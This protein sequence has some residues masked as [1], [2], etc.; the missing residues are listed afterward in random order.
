MPMAYGS[1]GSQAGTEE[2]RHKAPL[3]GKD[4]D[5]HYNGLED[6]ELLVQK[7]L[8]CGS[9][10][11]PPSPACGDCASLDWEPTALSGKGTIYSYTVHRHPPLPN[12]PVPH[13]IAVVEVE[14]GLRVVGAMDGTALE[15]MAIGK[16]VTTEFVRRG[17]AAGFRFKLA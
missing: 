9:L 11:N 15:D 13:P 1:A 4:Y 2:K 6:G 5:F 10:R 12:F 3:S 14:E 7:C 16:P 17:D 8:S